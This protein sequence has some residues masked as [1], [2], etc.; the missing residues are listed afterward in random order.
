MALDWRDWL[1]V[2]QVLLSIP[3]GTISSQTETATKHRASLDTPQGDCVFPLAALL[4]DGAMAAPTLP[5]ARNDHRSESLGSLNPQW[6]KAQIGNL[7]SKVLSASKSQDN[8]LNT[9]IDY[10]KKKKQDDFGH[11]SPSSFVICHVGLGGETHKKH[12]T[13]Q[14]SRKADP[15]KP[16]GK[17]HISWGSKQPAP[18]VTPAINSNIIW[19]VTLGGFGEILMMLAI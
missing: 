17:H 15:P 8:E 4:T 5:G 6:C 7:T 2:S 14:W 10:E 16:R 1:L 3:S 13:H 12:G 11:T 9:P 19:V 18:R